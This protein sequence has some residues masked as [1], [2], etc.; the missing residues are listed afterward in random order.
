MLI[1]HICGR[2]NARQAKNMPLPL[3]RRK[4]SPECSSAHQRDYQNKKYKFRQQLFKELL[5]ER[6]DIK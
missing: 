1:C 5:A 6:N 2:P 3:C 4:E